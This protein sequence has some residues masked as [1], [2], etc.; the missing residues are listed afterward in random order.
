V[1]NVVPGAYR[2]VSVA[3]VAVPLTAASLEAYFVGRE[4][5][6]RTRYV[7]VTSGPNT[8]LIEVDL[9]DREP[10]FSPAVSVSLLAGPEQTVAVRRP[11]I[12]TA[13]PSQLAKVVA[14]H[15]D[16][17]C[18]VVEGRYGH[19]SFLLD[20]API[21]VLVREVVP[22]HP[23]K[24]VEQAQR[25]LDLADDLPPMVLVPDLVELTALA[26]PA[27]D[28]LLPCRGSGIE[29]P[30]RQA[31]FLDERPP[32]RDWAL[33]GCARSR[34]IHRWFYGVDGPGVDLCPRR[35]A[36]DV[37]LGEDEE[38]VL[39][40]C[41]LLEADIESGPG[42]VVV[43]WGATI[44]QVRRALTDLARMAAAAWAPA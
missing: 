34:E 10:L 36:G 42:R 39:T 40:K 2:Q 15:P 3:K 37:A 28:I 13:V 18:V 11:E 26:P 8:A 25:V 5:Y 20:P 38:L 14:D 9:A 31:W 43:P 22:P 1:A 33:L 6:R 41:C 24:L 12:D 35:R 44:E 27:G 32:H 4:C 29:L 16:A 30:G 17:R 21:R 19:V 7:V 23:A